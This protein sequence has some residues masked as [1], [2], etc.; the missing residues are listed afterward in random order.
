MRLS[1]PFSSRAVGIFG[2]AILACAVAIAACSNQGEGD[3]CDVNA[4]NSGNDD[5]KDG[6]VCT[7]QSSLGNNS[8]TDLCCPSDR[9]LATTPQCAIPQ[10]PTGG[11]SG[12]PNVDGSVPTMDGGA[13]DSGEAGSDTGSA[14]ET[15]ASDAPNEGG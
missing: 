5:C 12:A 13:D 11:D 14:M 2:G 7:P 1:F 15:G 6:L 4:D 8:S 10:T 9:R 3:R